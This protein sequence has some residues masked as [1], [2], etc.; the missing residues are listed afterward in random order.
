MNYHK[1]GSIVVIIICV[2]IEYGIRFVN[3]FRCC[4][5]RPKGFVFAVISF[6]LVKFFRQISNVV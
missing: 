1:V 4:H 3:S 2:K 6:F 5:T